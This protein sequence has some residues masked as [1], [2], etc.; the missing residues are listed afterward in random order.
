VL[1]DENKRRTYDQYGEEGLK[2]NNNNMEFRNPFDIFNIFNHGQAQRGGSN[3]RKGNNVEIPLHVTLQD[4][5]L[6]TTVRMSHKKQTLCS[7]CRGTGAKNP[8]DVTTCPVCRGSG[9]KVETHQVGPGFITQ[10]QTTCDRCG[11]KGRIAKSVCGHC[12]GKKVSVGEEPITVVVE[13]GMKDGDEIKFE[14][15]ADEQPDMT[16]G[17]LIFKIVTDPHKRFTRMGDDLHTKLN[18]TLLEALVGFSKSIKHLD[19]H[20]VTVERSD[21]TVPGFVAKVE[22]EGMPRQNFASSEKGD[23]YVEFWVTFPASLTEA[24]KE[25]VKQLLGPAK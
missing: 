6:G 23:L 5:Y 13:Q 17:D 20:R 10:T 4:L 12:G 15:E 19:G 9:V 22:G 24:Q 14:S 16:P 3:Q 18:V 25:G 11:G 1:S 7:K 8:D 2:G 21:I